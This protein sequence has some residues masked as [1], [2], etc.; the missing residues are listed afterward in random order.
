VL[1]Y[2]LYWWNLFGWQDGNERSA[3]R[4]IATTAPYDFMG[5]QECDDVNRV[6]SDALTEGLGGDYAAIQGEHAM[7]IVYKRSDWTVIGQ[8]YEDV[9][10]DA[11]GLYGVRGSNFARLRHNT[12]GRVVFFAN[13]HGPLPVS[14]DG[15][16]RGS[17]VGYN[18]VNMIAHNR[19]PGDVVILVG[20][21]NAHNDSSRIHA[22]D[23]HLNRVHSG[24][25][26]EGVDHIFT[27]VPG[28]AVRTYNHGKGGSDH[29]AISAVLSV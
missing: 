20:D 28:D 3:G 8:G 12:H 19:H 29:D 4:K 6:L 18:I 1:T 11:P 25:C 21:F 10:E 13:H 5:F 14:A 26:M 7:A 15:D 9:G 23:A 22:L 27:S 24:T 17:T 16:C 2:N